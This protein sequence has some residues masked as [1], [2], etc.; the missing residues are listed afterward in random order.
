MRTLSFQRTSL[1]VLLL[2]LAF[3]A[4]EWRAVYGQKG[5]PVTDDEIVDLVRI[6]LAG[7]SMVKGGAIQVECKQGVVTLSGS[8]ETEKQKARAERLAKKVKGVKQVVN[9]LVIR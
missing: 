1:I 9:K 6:K 4:C 3:V 2:G 7:D 5:H 8:V